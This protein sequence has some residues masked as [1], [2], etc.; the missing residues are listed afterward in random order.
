MTSNRYLDA[1]LPPT[2]RDVSRGMEEE[3]ELSEASETWLLIESDEVPEQWSHRSMR[4]TVIRLAPDEAKRVLS[5][6][7]ARPIIGP[8]HEELAHLVASGLSVTQMSQQLHLTS[9]SVYR[10]L[11]RLRSVFGVAT[12]NELATKL[13]RL[14]Y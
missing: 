13:S 7:H 4:I 1:A 5:N 6:D 11:A 3:R 8:E 10:R 2:L 14:G 9:R 12:L